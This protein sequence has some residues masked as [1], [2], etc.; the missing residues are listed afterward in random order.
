VGLR[1][2]PVGSSR[3]LSSILGQQTGRD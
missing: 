1:G 3:D 2:S